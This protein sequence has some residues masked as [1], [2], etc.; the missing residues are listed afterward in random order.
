MRTKTWL[1]TLSVGILL[2]A[3]VAYGLLSE[4]GQPV[5]P[6]ASAPSVRN[7]PAGVTTPT[8]TA[9]TP[10]APTPPPA[11]M[12]AAPQA[13]QPTQP[14]P[15][16]TPTPAPPAAI[17]QP[18]PPTT[19]PHGGDTASAGA[20]TDA[21]PAGRGPAARAT[22]YSTGSTAGGDTIIPLTGTNAG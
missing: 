7:V 8:P 3:G 4:R 11:P 9:A 6:Q 13:A 20:A 15:E 5:A 21:S 18:T 19:A 16:P 12:A 22:D 10:P 14:A 2:V 17:P 1:V